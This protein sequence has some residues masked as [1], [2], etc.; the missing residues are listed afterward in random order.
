MISGFISETA[1]LTDY[2]RNELLPVVVAGL[3][4]KVG[5]EKA[6]TS[7]YIC[8]RL[9]AA[10]YKVDGARLR[11]VIN[12]IRLTGLVRRLIATSEG[13]YISNSREELSQYIH[14]LQGREES[15]RSVRRALE[16]QNV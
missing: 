2:E 13:Y 16:M 12:H 6:V 11:K 10:G 1:P 15:I 9:R 8:S 7:G 14:S 4:N 5:R 3:R